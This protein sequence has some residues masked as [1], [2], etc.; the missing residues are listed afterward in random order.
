VEADALALL[1]R[2]EHSRLELARKLAARR[3][4]DDAVEAVL[5]GLTE[6]GLLS[7][8]RM[9]EAYV[10]ERLRKGFGP[11]RVRR[12]LRER[13]VSDA[14]IDPHLDRTAGEWLAQ[15]AEV[16]RR[17]FGAEPATDAR[18]LARRARFLEYRGFPPE[19]I[20]RFLLRGR[21]D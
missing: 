10:E 18:D 11:L 4:E 8:A 19:L 21:V 20:G 12:E 1:A 16:H 5:D 15:M 17:K 13:G 14:L 6:Q 7:D 3:H 2:R 9:A